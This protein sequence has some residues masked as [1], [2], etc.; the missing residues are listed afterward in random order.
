MDESIQIKDI[1][2]MAGWKLYQRK[3]EEEIKREV[4]NL[5]RIEIEGRSLQ[6]IGA[7]YVR[8]IQKINGLYRAKEIPE[9]IKESSESQI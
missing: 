9:E 7:E 4:D 6:D 8:I 5:R 3:V 1:E 2:K